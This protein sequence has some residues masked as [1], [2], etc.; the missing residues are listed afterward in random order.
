MDWDD[1]QGTLPGGHSLSRYDS[2]ASTVVGGKSNSTSYPDMSAASS[3]T[4]M[5]WSN[6]E[7]TLQGSHSPGKAESDGTTTAGPM[8]PSGNSNFTYSPDG[9]RC[10]PELSELVSQGIHGGNNS[11]EDAR[12]KKLT[13]ITTNCDV[14][15]SIARFCDKETGG[16]M[17]GIIKS[18]IEALG[19]VCTFFQQ[20]EGTTGSD[21]AEALLLYN[22]PERVAKLT[23]DF[24]TLQSSFM[25]LQPIL[26]SYEGGKIVC[27]ALDSLLAVPQDSR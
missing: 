16:D 12:S 26:G 15:C 20:S 17:S 22:C 9:T 27:D 25:S 6:S 13:A 24:Q 14:L 8:A 7:G 4:N 19:H 23:Q 3:D 2:D 5:D 18:A 1:S 21:I 11:L 10:L